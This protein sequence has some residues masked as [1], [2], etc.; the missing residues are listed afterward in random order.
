MIIVLEVWKY[1]TK[2]VWK[3]ETKDVWSFSKRKPTCN[4]DPILLWSSTS[5]SV[6]TVKKYNSKTAL[7]KF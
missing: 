3:Y 7:S 2:D 1:E 5:E 4:T 6:T